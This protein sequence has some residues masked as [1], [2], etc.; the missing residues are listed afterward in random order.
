MVSEDL[1]RPFFCK[2]KTGRRRKKLK[3]KLPASTPKSWSW[4]QVQPKPHENCPELHLLKHWN[5]SGT[6]TQPEAL[7]PSRS[8]WNFLRIPGSLLNPM[9]EMPLWNS[10]G[11]WQFDNS[12]YLLLCSTTFLELSRTS[13]T[14][15]ATPEPNYWVYC[16]FHSTQSW[17]CQLLTSP[18][19]GDGVCR[20]LSAGTSVDIQNVWNST[21]LLW[22]HPV[23]KLQNHPEPP[24]PTKVRRSFWNL[25]S[26]GTCWSLDPQCSD[27]PALQ[28]TPPG[29][30]VRPGI[31]RSPT[32]KPIS[33]AHP[34][35]TN[36]G[37][38]ISKTPWPYDFT[39]ASFKNCNHAI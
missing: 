33:A 13:M 7:H 1:K 34:P 24:E 25:W 36:V 35:S 8:C 37:G 9:R 6:S 16:K 5:P 10:I 20:K 3:A 18:W 31:F 4:K 19:K 11:G 22:P 38:L 39:S 17:I 28:N 21:T 2:I 27:P 30:Q 32:P 12:R 23:P 14:K 29:L 15:L 26:C